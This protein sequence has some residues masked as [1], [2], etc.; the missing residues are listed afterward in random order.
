MTLRNLMNELIKNRDFL[1]GKVVKVSENTIYG[2]SLAGVELIG[3]ETDG[4]DISCMLDGKI[5][6]LAFSTEL[7]I[8]ST[9]P[10]VNLK[11]IYANY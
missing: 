9:K 2:T 5:E 8:S 1:E 7:E 6:F 11:E 10:L 4:S 3:F